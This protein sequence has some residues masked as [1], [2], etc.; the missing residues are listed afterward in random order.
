MWASTPT[1]KGKR[2]DV[3]IVPYKKE[4]IK[5]IKYMKGLGLYIHIPF[6]VSKCKYCD[7]YSI[8]GVDEEGKDKY[9]EA[10]LC[11][12]SEYKLQT[13]N[14]VVSSVYLGGGTPSLLSEK[15]LKT[16][17]K[18]VKKNFRLSQRCEI[19]MEV[20]PGTVDEHKLRAIRK[21]GV[22]RLSI[23]AQSFHE[24]ELRT[25]GR[26]HTP[27]EIYGCILD[28][29]KAKFENIS[30]DLMY[31]LPSQ[32]KK[33]LF[34]N[35][36]NAFNMN[37]DHISLYGLKIEEGTPFW[38]DRHNLDLPDEDEEREMYF[39]AVELLR[40][41]G[42]RQYEISNFAKRHKA[43]KHNLRYWNCDEYI[44]F[45]PGAHSYFGGKRFS[46][47]KNLGLYINSFN[48][49]NKPS[50]TLVDEYIDIPPQ[51]HVAEYVMLRFR[52]H[53]GVNL[54]KFYKRFGRSFEDM[55]YEKML[56][57]LNSGH[58]IK[59][60]TGYAFSLDGM[61]VSNYILSRIVGEDLVI[62]GVEQ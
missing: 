45:G 17:M 34:E 27:E 21:T 31:G 62:P 60:K 53:E 1:K 36:D 55:Y 39:E 51:A 14:Y 19:S 41:A 32:T 29:R 9:L 42:Y 22:N 2:D 11:H 25:C 26:I 23:G 13:K 47:K 61:Y 12:M 58:I 18:A 37:V 6:C 5:V 52:L 24:G 33:A 49:N 43:C 44:G 3:S 38:Y 30:L 10:L 4:K 40:H 7:F 46:F 54:A 56:P 8:A 50:E 35:L 20:N 57:F 16:L 59:N 15:Q 48:E 28:A